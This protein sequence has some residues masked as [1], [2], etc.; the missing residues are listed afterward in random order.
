M[1]HID[2]ALE[3]SDAGKYAESVDKCIGKEH[4]DDL[5][6][7]LIGNASPQGGIFAS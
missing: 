3:R 6:M 4:V 7:I 2:A 1:P 5:Q